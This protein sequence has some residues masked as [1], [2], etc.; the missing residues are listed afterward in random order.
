MLHSVIFLSLLDRPTV[1]YSSTQKL[2]FSN[3]NVREVKHMCPLN[4]SAYP[5]SLALASDSAISI[6]TIDEIQ[7]AYSETFHQTLALKIV[8]FL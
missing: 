8:I 4:S 2:V 7:V 6:G 1:I 5:G 3:V